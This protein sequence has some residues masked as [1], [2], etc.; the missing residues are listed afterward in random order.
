MEKK[1][2]LEE[3]IDSIS[4]EELK[5][6]VGSASDDDLIE[7][8]LMSIKDMFALDTCI[9]TGDLLRAKV[10]A[11][12]VNRSLTDDELLEIA[13]TSLKW[14]NP[15]ISREAIGELSEKNNN[16]KLFEI[17]KDATEKSCIN[18]VVA[19]LEKVVVNSD[20]EAK[21][22]VT[23]IQKLKLGVEQRDAQLRRLE[24]DAKERF[25]KKRSSGAWSSIRNFFENHN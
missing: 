14:L 6:T 3:V 25:S 9:K 8:V 1:S 12:K 7:N 15:H 19:A 23:Q 13:R 16:E 10:L 17:A 24:D 21:I 4:L 11:G 5:R 2:V 20:E 18:L 22:K